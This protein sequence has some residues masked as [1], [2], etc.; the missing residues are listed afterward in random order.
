[1]GLVRQLGHVENHVTCLICFRQRK[2]CQLS[3]DNPETIPDSLKRTNDASRETRGVR[4][5]N[6][7]THED[8]LVWVR[9]KEHADG[10]QL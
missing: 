10:G 5:H 2:I 9:I 8:L 1:M 7:Y 3:L 6:F 4:V